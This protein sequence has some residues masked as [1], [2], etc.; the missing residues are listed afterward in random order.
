MEGG[1]DPFNRR[2]YPWGNEDAP[3]L[4]FYRKTGALRTAH[5]DILTHGYY[6][7]LTAEG[8]L[9]AILREEREAGQLLLVTNSGDGALSYSID[10]VYR[11]V[12]SDE[13]VSGELFLPPISFRLLRSLSQ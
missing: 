13:T 5:A 11:D 3:L 12:Y 8:P 1:R 7:V 4:A 9:L 2:T 6:R 10:G